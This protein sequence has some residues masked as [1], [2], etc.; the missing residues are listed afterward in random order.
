MHTGKTAALRNIWR[1]ENLDNELTTQMM[2]ADDLP[3]SSSEK[4]L[5]AEAK[6]AYSHSLLNLAIY[7]VLS[8]GLQNIAGII[9]SK[10]SDIPLTVNSIWNIILSFCPMYL[11]ALPIYLLISKKMKVSPP[12]KQKLL[13]TDFLTYLCIGIG[14]ML[15]GNLITMLFVAAVGSTTGVDVSNDT[16]QTMMF[17][18]NSKVMVLIALF[19]A[20]IVEEMLFR[21]VFIDRVRKYG[22][23]TAIVL[24]GVLFGLFHGNFSQ[25]FYAALLGCMLAFVYVKT[26][27]VLYTM[28][29]HLCINFFGGAVATLLLS[30]VTDVGGL[31][32]GGQEWLFEHLSEIR[33]YLLYNVLLYTL[34]FVGVVLFIYRMAEGTFFT[35][36]ESET[37][38][39]KKS[40]WLAACINIG[41]LAF[42]ICV[43]FLF[44][45]SI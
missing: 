42:L 31:L 19:G 35:L 36:N 12:K 28:A 41:M 10:C 27:N 22:D 18:D 21:K 32:S 43:G 44:V 34:A 30:D 24:S 40:R 38:L 1:N 2:N 15:V 26:G 7:L 8:I 13:P 37:V 23:G 11:I 5:F 9:Y 20:P 3:Q 4:E 14:A 25:V 17:S 16:L 45:I 6:G 39:S 29:L 33:P